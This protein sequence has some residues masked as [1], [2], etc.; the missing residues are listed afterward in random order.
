MT[1]QLLGAGGLANRIV[2]F[3][4]LFVGRL[5][6]GLSIVNSVACMFFGNLSGSAVAGT[7][8]IGSVM[9]PIMPEG[10]VN[11]SPSLHRPP[12]GFKAASPR[13]PRKGLTVR[14]EID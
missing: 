14:R 6:G 4:N 5:P 8:A 11:R 10:T 3:T 7:S 1:G 9:I 12:P 13:M 2:D